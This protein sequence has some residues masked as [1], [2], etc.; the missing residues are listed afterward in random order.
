MLTQDDLDARRKFEG[1]VFLILFAL[2]I[3]PPIG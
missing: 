1:I 3:P 2:T